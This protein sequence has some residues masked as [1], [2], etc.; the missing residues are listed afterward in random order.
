MNAARQITHPPTVT[1]AEWLTALDLQLHSE[2]DLSLDEV[3]RVWSP[4]DMFIAWAEGV[5]PL[6]LTFQ[7]AEG[8]T[9]SLT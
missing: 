3:L 5:T 4:G 8:V 2:L 6:R 9:A 7:I 1:F